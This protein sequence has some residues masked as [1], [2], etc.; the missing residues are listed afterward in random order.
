MFLL[1][2]HLLYKVYMIIGGGVF[3]ISKTMFSGNS[4]IH[5]FV[6]FARAFTHNGHFVRRSRALENRVIMI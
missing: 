3:R 2:L 4:A 1:G 5:D 6:F